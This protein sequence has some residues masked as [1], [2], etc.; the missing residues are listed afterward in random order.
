MFYISLITFCS[1]RDHHSIWTRF[2]RL[3]VKSEKKKKEEEQAQEQDDY[4]LFESYFL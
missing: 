1:K 2:C 4:E 3:C